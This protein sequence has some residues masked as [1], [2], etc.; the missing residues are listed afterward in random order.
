MLKCFTEVLVSF[1][2]KKNI[3]FKKESKMEVIT[4]EICNAESKELKIQT[5][6][7]VD[8]K[9]LPRLDTIE[10][11]KQVVRRF[12]IEKPK[13]FETLRSVLTAL[14]YEL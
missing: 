6:L 5:W 8:D 7:V 2:K 14:L 12:K 9:K 11:I 10:E 3:C 13:E 4:V 1:L